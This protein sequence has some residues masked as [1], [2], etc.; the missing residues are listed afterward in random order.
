MC[1]VIYMFKSG[2]VIQSFLGLVHVNDILTTSLEKGIYSLLS[3]HDGLST[4]N[5]KGKRY[6]GASNAAVNSNG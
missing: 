6:D 3:T 4:S 5:L 1:V 2:H